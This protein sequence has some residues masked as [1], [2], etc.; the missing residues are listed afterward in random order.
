METSPGIDC[1][2][3]THYNISYSAHAYQTFGRS[4]HEKLNILNMLALPT[5][6]DQTVAHNSQIRPKNNDIGL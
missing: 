6:P 1:N 2:A 4:L 5:R 3:N